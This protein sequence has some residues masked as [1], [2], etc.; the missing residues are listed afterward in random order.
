MPGI[1][2]FH[3][4]GTDRHSR[5]GQPDN[6]RFFFQQS[7]DR[8]HGHMTFDDVALNDRYVALPEFGRY[9]VLR[10]HRIQLDIRHIDFFHL[11]AI[12]L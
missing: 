2:A 6:R 7:S 12:P 11:E 3:A 10:V 4:G 5:Y 9:A 8:I 1:G